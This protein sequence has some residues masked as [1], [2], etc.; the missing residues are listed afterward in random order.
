MEREDP[1]LLDQVRN[2]MRMRHMSHKPER[3]FTEDMRKSILVHNKYMAPK[4]VC[5]VSYEKLSETTKIQKIA[6]KERTFSSCFFL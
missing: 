2:L 4:E 3:S 1:K 6:R 5:K